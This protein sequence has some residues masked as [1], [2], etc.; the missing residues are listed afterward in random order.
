MSIFHLDGNHKHQENSLRGIRRAKRAG[1]DEIDLDI[2]MD[3]LGN[4]YG[5]HWMLPMVHDG[6]HDTALRHRMP[7]NTR[8]DHMLPGQ[9]RRLVALPGYRILPLETLLRGCARYGIV[10]RLEPKDDNRFEDAT[11]WVGIAKLADAIGAH[12]RM[13]ALPDLGHKGSGALKVAAAAKAG[14]PGRLIR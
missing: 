13:Y 3:K 8:L 5:C 9:V 12:V 14:I 11:T 1:D 4:I 2:L 6:F 10:A 7:K